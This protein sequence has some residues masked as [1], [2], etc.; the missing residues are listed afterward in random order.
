[1]YVTCKVGEWQQVYGFIRHDI[2]RVRHKKNGC[3][4]IVVRLIYHHVMWDDFYMG[5]RLEGKQEVTSLLL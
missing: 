3:I 5:V 4:R 2:I 1:M